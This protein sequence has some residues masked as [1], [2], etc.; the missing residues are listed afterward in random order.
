MVVTF[1]TIHGRFVGKGLQI[2]PNLLCFE[3]FVH[4]FDIFLKEFHRKTEI[5]GTGTKTS[6]CEFFR[7]YARR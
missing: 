6:C 7:A 4:Y 5:D 3:C 1:L 2:S